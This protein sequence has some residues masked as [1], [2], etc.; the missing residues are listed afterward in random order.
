MRYA[1]AN[2]KR[3]ERPN[4]EGAIVNA[5]PAVAWDFPRGV[6]PVRLHLAHRVV[7]VAL[8]VRVRREVQ[9]VSVVRAGNAMGAVSVTRQLVAYRLQN[10]RAR[11]SANADPWQLR[12]NVEVEQPPR[13]ED[14]CGTHEA[15]LRS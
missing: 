11:A 15:L 7:Q 9:A 3:I 5:P 14:D 2:Q 8:A 13:N 10:V 4:N 1:V 12:P 6:P